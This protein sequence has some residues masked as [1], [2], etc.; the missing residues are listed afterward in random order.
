M[1]SWLRIVRPIN[2]VM[3]IVATII[4]GFI[5]VG[6]S[7]PSHAYAVIAASA[8]VFFVTAGGNVINDYV[9]VETDRINHPDRPLVTGAISRGAARTAFLAFF[10]VAIVISAV[11]ISITAL[12]VVLLA[13]AFLGLYEFRTKKMGFPGN[14]M[15]SILVGL[16]FVFGGIAVDV[17][18]KMLI[19]FVMA[20]LANLSREIIKDIQDVEGDVDRKTL[21]KSI[22]V[23]G[24]SAVAVV[25]VLVAVSFSYLP[26]YFGIF[27]L[28]YLFIVAVADAMFVLSAI[29]IIR[30]PGF[31]QQISK[32]AMIIGLLSFA[33]GGII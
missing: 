2:G 6:F 22:G 27:H 3:G 29:T 25:S 24:A 28:Y 16:I 23:K 13:E 21:P 5:G 1:N 15:I 7:L 20:T 30:N 17:V 32:F 10:I 4:S 11:L 8:A 14:A 26:Y 33:V 18:N 31:S 12:V 19:L 9:D